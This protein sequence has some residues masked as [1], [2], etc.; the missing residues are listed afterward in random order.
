MPTT[1][2]TLTDK[3][4]PK[5]ADMSE[6]E[7]AR[8]IKEK[9]SAMLYSFKSSVTH[10]MDVGDLL[11]EAKRRVEHG[12]FEAWLS[13][14][15]QLSFRTARRYMA[16]AKDRKKIE[17]KLT[18]KSDSLADLSAQRLL[19]DQTGGGGAGGNQ[20][21]ASDKYDAVQAKLIEKLQ[22]LDVD[23]AEAAAET[24]N[25]ELRKTVATMKAGAKNKAA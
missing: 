11:I 21:N 18:S 17:A 22:D 13:T 4:P 24:T 14:H 15:C 19:T 5:I 9:V 3:P 7:L 1:P 20:K 8:S 16:M 12:N 25:K 6:E 2:S 10:A 23:A